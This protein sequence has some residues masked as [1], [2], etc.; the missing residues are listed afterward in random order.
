MGNKKWTRVLALV[1]AL[2]CTLTVVAAGEIGSFDMNGDGKVT[3]WDLQVL[4]N[5][6]SKDYD[7]ALKQV[8]GGHG[9]ELNPNENGEYEIYTELGL[10][11]MAR[12]AANADYTF[13]LKNDIDLNGKSWAPVELRGTFNGNGHTISNV[14]IDTDRLVGSANVQGFFAKIHKGAEVKDLNLNK[15]EIT[16]QE[17]TRFIGL[18]AGT[19]Y[20]TVTNCTTT[21][22]VIDTREDLSALTDE[23]VYIGTLLGRSENANN[24]S[25]TVNITDDSVL[26]HAED[27]E[28]LLEV[29]KEESLVDRKARYLSTNNGWAYES[30]GVQD[31]KANLRNWIGEEGQAVISKMAMEYAELTAGSRVTKI[32]AIGANSGTDLSGY[33]WQDTSGSIAEQD[34]EIANR[35]Q[36]VVNAMYDM[37]TVEW[38]PAKDMTSYFY[39]WGTSKVSLNSNRQYEV[40]S[41]SYK[42]LPY[43]HGAGS[44][45]RFENYQDEDT[46]KLLSSVPATGV[47]V[48]QGTDFNTFI[49]AQI[50]AKQAGNSHQTT[51][52]DGTNIIPILNL[53]SVSG[54]EQPYDFTLP[55]SKQYDHA[56]FH[57]YLGNDCSSAVQ[58]AWRKVVSSNTATGGTLISGV[59][60]MI[61]NQNNQSWYGMADV[62]GLVVTD[63]NTDTYYTSLGD[64]AQEVVMEAYAKASRGDALV[65][66]E[67]VDKEGHSRMIAYDPVVIR[68]SDGDIDPNRSYFITHEQGRTSYSVGYTHY[69]GSRSGWKSD[70]TV[71]CLYTFDMLTEY[72][73]KYTSTVDN[74]WA[75]GAPGHYMPVS[76]AAFQEENLGNAQAVTSS[77]TYHD[78]VV[79]SNFYIVST[80]VDGNEVFTAATQHKH[81]KAINKKGESKNDYTGNGYRDAQLDVNLAETHGDLT[82]KA[83]VVRLSNGD[84]WTVLN[85]AITQ[86]KDASNFK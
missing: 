84:E 67:G 29:L 46:K 36:A 43:T 56:G 24:L 45:E 14:K 5:N 65:W 23:K 81:E 64:N 12:N 47:Y 3:V 49:T 77:V 83:V 71:N 57:R 39:G 7:A 8:L 70:C 32:V 52:T 41:I 15:V 82:D 76:I 28:K 58:W 86:T 25:S 19:S 31:A 73:S 80:A 17:N 27:E 35:R 13:V 59:L 54:N 37:C 2:V 78:G 18:L 79:S 22:K 21:G 6:Q 38:K 48:N 60:D 63:L 72:G 75:I 44:L 68:E 26:L 53:V 34:E 74:N 51:Y 61:P 20:G 9:D 30:Q 11:N 1:M 10:R 16:A 66:G 85:G 69:A 62:G 55:M 42:G 4:F 50:E 33:Y 40:S